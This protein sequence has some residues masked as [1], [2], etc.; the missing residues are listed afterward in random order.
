[1]SRFLFQS[2]LARFIGRKLE[3][4]Q[5]TQIC[6]NYGWKRLELEHIRRFLFS[7]VLSIIAEN[8]C[9]VFER[10]LNKREKKFICIE[11]ALKEHPFFLIALE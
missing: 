4:L 11:R 5:K 10:V 1:M 3:K 2:I 6:R 8:H 9:A 7:Q